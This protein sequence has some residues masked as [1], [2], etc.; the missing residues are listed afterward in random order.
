MRKKKT[1]I[2]GYVL[3]AGDSIFCMYI[4]RD[5]QHVCIGSASDVVRAARRL[6]LAGAEP[7]TD[8]IVRESPWAKVV[9]K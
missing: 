7:A 6:V 1:D 4:V 8:D 5:G 3:Q 9:Q 2:A